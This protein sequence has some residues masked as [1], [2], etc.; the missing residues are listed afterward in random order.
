M[1]NEPEE[2]LIPPCAYIN[3][4][5]VAAL[6]KPSIERVVEPL[7]RNDKLPFDKSARIRLT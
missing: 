5:N 4:E 7:A 2:T 1:T 3:P 6:L